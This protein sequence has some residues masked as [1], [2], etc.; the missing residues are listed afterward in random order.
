MR[1][2]GSRSSNPPLCLPK[3]RSAVLRISAG[4]PQTLRRMRHQGERPGNGKNI[5]SNKSEQELCS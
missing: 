2:S 5:Q 1:I 4:L 3:T